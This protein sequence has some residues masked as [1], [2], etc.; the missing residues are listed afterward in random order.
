MTE[1]YEKFKQQYTSTGQTKAQGYDESHFAGLTS[2]EKGDVY[3]LLK[4]EALAPGNADWM[5]K[6]HPQKAEVFL[7]NL[8]KNQE[9]ANSGRA[10]HLYAALYRYTKKDQYKERLVQG[11][12]YAPEY[13]HKQIAWLVRTIDLPRDEKISFYKNGIIDEKVKIK[14]LLAD[15][16]LNVKGYDRTDLIDNLTYDDTIKLISNSDN[17]DKKRILDRLDECSSGMS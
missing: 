5:L 11:F 12:S 4:E 9:H 7:S 1:A 17:E 3:K 2:E 6:I 16:Y 8:A 15:F 14:S 10:A 13:E